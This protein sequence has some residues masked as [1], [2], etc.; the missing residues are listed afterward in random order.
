MGCT[1]RY[2]S[3][4][5]CMTEAEKKLYKM[6]IKSF[7]KFLNTIDKRIVIMPC[8]R[9]ADFV[10][11]RGNLDTN[12]KL[13]YSITSKHIDYLIC[14]GTTLDIIFAVELDDY[15]H[16]IPDKIARDKKVEKI[17]NECGIKLFR[18]KEQIRK[19]DEKT[20]D[21]MINYLLSYYAPKCPKC[22][23]QTVLKISKQNTNYGHRFYGCSEWNFGNGCDYNLSIG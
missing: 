3:K 17:L 21:P 10:G 11:V 18:I 22:G 15:Y 1:S 14:D 5:T 20:L 2:Y 4:H 7:N 23:A 9:I 8:V 6:M 13:L 19:V 16:N 12:R